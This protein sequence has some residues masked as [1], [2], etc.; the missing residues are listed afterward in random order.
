[1]ATATVNE[2][3]GIVE[4]PITTEQ[5]SYARVAITTKNAEGNDV[6]DY[7]VMS[8]DDAEALVNGKVEDRPAAYKTAKLEIEVKQSFAFDHGNT[9][10]ALKELFTDENGVVNEKELCKQTNNAVDVKLGNRVRQLLTATDEDGNFTFE[11]QEGAFSLRK[12]ISEATTARG[13]STLEKMKEML[14][15]LPPDQR[16]QFKAL[17]EAQGGE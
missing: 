1:M 8:Q 5:R 7:K 9:I 6:V 10:T 3:P 12:Y 17:L 16:A 4:I 13:K 2:Q 14:A 11:P 15:K